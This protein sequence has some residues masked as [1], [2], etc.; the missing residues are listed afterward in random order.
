METSRPQES[1]A[2]D[3]PDTQA[4]KSGE[5]RAQQGHGA[6][7][8]LPHERDQSSDSQQNQDGA[9]PDVGR[10]GLADMKHG[11]VDT[12]RGPVLDQ[13]YNEKVKR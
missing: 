3:A 13:V 5:T 11:M 7:P 8:R 9:T 12:D 4:R 1:V 10:Q 6:V 2:T